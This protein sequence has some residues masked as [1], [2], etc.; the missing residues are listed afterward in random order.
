MASTAL[1]QG[2]VAALRFA[3]FSSVI[4]DAKR[5]V[6]RG[7]IEVA[8]VQVCGVGDQAFGAVLVLNSVSVYQTHSTAPGSQCWS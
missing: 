7:A 4:L 3:S 1:G 2:Q 8:L 5:I 6:F